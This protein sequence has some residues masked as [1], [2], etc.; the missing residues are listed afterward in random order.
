MKRCVLVIEAGPLATLCAAFATDGLEPMEYFCYDSIG[1][2]SALR[3]LSEELGKKG[4][5]PVKTL[6]SIHSSLLSMRLLEIPVKDRRKLQEIISLQSEDLFMKGPESMVLDGLP[7]AG[8]KAA[9]AGVEKNELA[10]Q[11]KSLIDAG[12]APSWAGP[13][14]FSKGLILKKLGQTEG[15]AAFIDDDS[16]TVTRDGQAFFFKH[17]ETVDDL[18]LS[19]AAL[20][21]DGV[22]I[23]K[24]FSAG[25]NG[26]AEKAGIAAQKAGSEYE[27][28]SLLAV[29][30]QFKE[31]LKESVNF[32]KW[33]ADPK[34]Q[35]A[36][37]RRFRAAVA[38]SAALVLSWGAYAYLRYQNISAETDSI[39]SVIE[40][41]FNE[42][43]PGEVSKNPEYALEVKLKELAVDRKVLSGRAEVLTAMLEL[44][45]AASNGKGLRTHEVQMS[46]NRLNL[47]SEAG[48]F[49]EAAAFRESVSKAAPLKKVTI[50]E[51]KPAPNGRVR[52]NMS[53]ELGGL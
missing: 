52:F 45:K 23:E 6:L 12:L 47:S 36:L 16:I 48:S 5:K 25:S 37:K 51:T 24:Y 19:L 3:Q 1:L 44:S 18:L 46:G 42:L 33:H 7:L 49:E 38:L 17:L 22:K 30:L 34:A 50:T 40:Q 9:A 39:A 14:I 8:G 53:A 35:G 43:F 10:S 27:H 31:G 41:G 21:A 20:E 26:L 32:L 15:A 2:D 11:L 29:A 4:L 28:P 13:A